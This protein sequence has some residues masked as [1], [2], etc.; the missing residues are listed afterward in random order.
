MTSGQEMERV[1]SFN[2]G[3]HTGCRDRSGDPNFH[4]QSHICVETSLALFCRARD[5]CRRLLTGLLVLKH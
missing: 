2:P 3:A 5:F 4:P 1:Y